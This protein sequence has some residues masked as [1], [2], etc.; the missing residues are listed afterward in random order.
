MTQKKAIFEQ[1]LQRLACPSAG[2]VLY[3]IRTGLEREALRVESEGRLSSH[4]HPQ[5]LGSALTHPHIT[6]DYS[7]AMLELVTAPGGLPE[8]FQFLKVL[9]QYVYRH[10]GPEILWA[11]SMPC[12]TGAEAQVPIARYGDS[13]PGKMKTA[14][15]RGL[16]YRYG[17]AMQLISGIHYNFS[18]PKAYWEIETQETFDQQ[19][20]SERYFDLIRNLLRY[21]WLVPYLFGASPAVCRSFVD[22]EA[23]WL[24][25]FT[26]ETYYGPY[27]TSL[28]LGDIGYQN[29]KESALGIRVDYNNLS[30]YIESLRHA[31]RTSC[32][33]YAEIGL[34]EDG[35]YLQLNTNL[36][37]IEN[38]YYGPV[39]PKCVPQG[40]EKPTRGL[41]LRG[42]E[43]IELRTLDI[44]PFVP[45]GVSYEE[46]SFLPALILY[47][48]LEESP[49]I[50][51]DEYAVL[52][53]NMQQVAEHGRN[54]ELTLRRRGRDVPM[55]SWAQDLL[56]R[57][58]PLSVLLS[59]AHGSAEF[60]DAWQMQKQKAENPDFTYSAL[61][62]HAMRENRAG[63]V[64]WTLQRSREHRDELRK[65]KLD[66][67]AAGILD[68]MAA[69]SVAE[70][71]S[72]E[73]AD[74]SD[75]REY[76]EAYEMQA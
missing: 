4:A 63:Y 55:R 16:G 36:L 65:Q 66:D 62:L 14:Y 12:I 74:E 51:E 70:Q 68:D 67:A 1:R 27:A 69:W 72:L 41:R 56:E 48:L 6:T 76:L 50:A 21:G 40:N 3:W 47:C 37:Q 46:L 64:E 61:V 17:R 60:L 71:Q 57:I 8:S 25:S 26:P 10:L 11:G 73:K 59:E 58:Y 52:A 7:E 19:Y 31:T 75:F 32:R 22:Y 23:G 45:H 49:P 20:V 34:R 29:R 30:R 2:K 24:E 38:E 35:R 18:M 13:N 33:E 44:N 28:R 53:H 43:Y 42:V 15:R 5:M 39:R 54:P 9:H